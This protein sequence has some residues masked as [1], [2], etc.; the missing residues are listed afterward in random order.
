MGIACR[1]P[2]FGGDMRKRNWIYGL[3]YAAALLIAFILMG[4]DMW[5]DM[6]AQPGD[7]SV[8][9]ILAIMALGLS[10]TCYGLYHE[11]HKAWAYAARR[12][13]VR[14]RFA[15]RRIPLQPAPRRQQALQLVLQR[16]AH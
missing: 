10:A 4:M 1:C 9:V 6:A 2:L 3:S 16:M 13:E 8:I 7:A 15:R 14:T 11:R 12:L 5:R